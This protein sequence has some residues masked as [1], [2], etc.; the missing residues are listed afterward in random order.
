MLS[1]LDEALKGIPTS[2]ETYLIIVGAI[3]IV[4]AF[5]GV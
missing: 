4:V 2:P 1:Y 3:G 5:V